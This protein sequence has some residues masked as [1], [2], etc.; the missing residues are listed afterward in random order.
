MEICN[1]ANG[2][3]GFLSQGRKPV[4]F[5]RSG[6][7]GLHSRHNNAGHI[8]FRVSW[9]NRALIR[10]EILA[11]RSIMQT[12]PVALSEL[13]RL[14]FPGGSE[15]IGTSEQRS[16]VVQWASV[17]NLPLHDESEV[18]EDDLV[19]L[20]ADA[21]EPELLAAIAALAQAES[22]RGRAHR[23]AARTGD[24][25]RPAGQIA[26]HPSAQPCFAAANAPGRADA[27]HQSAGADDPARARRC[28][29]SWNNWWPKGPGWKRSCGRWP[30]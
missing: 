6:E 20:P 17:I 1:K 26:D 23:P 11:R 12:A 8:P 5:G 24:Q 9:Y 25:S 18:E 7:R 10:P 2:R 29:S 15:F 16:R 13:L 3:T 21:A 30:T 14:A 27:H 28:G 4:C 22:R 19:L